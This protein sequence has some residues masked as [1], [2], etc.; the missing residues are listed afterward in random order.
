MARV[1]GRGTGEGGRGKAVGR[2]FC[3]LGFLFISLFWVFF[4]CVFCFFH[5]KD[6][7]DLKTWLMTLP[8]KKM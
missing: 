5:I 1:A 7:K 2:I 3:F 8:E 6:G 4:V